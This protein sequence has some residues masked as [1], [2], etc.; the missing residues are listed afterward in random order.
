MFGETYACMG[1]KS[2]EV[3]IEALC[4]TKVLAI[5]VER[6]DASCLI[7]AYFIDSLI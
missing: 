2:A 3:S 4:D 6:I 1:L 7:P 5:D